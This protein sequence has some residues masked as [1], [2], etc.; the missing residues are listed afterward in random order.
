MRYIFAIMVILSSL[1]SAQ[2][3]THPTGVSDA[4]PSRSCW[5]LQSSPN[6]SFLTLT[7]PARINTQPSWRTCYTNGTPCGRWTTHVIGGYNLL[8][9]PLGCFP[10]VCVWHVDPV[11][12]V[13]QTLTVCHPTTWFVPWPAPIPLDG[14]LVGAVIFSQALTWEPSNPCELAVTQ[15]LAITI[16]A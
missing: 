6:A 7:A 14:S 8:G 3:P 12:A 13:S 11:I 4:W 1:L 9:W 15:A 16:Q 2:C 10:N 5:M